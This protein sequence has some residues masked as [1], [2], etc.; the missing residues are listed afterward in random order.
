MAQPKGKA[1]AAKKGKTD[2]A[3]KPAGKPAPAKNLE[4]ALK[5]APPPPAQAKNPFDRYLE[6]L[7]TMPIREDALKGTGLTA[8]DIR[9]RSESDPEFARKLSLAWDIGIDVAEDAAFRRGIIGWDEPVFT[10]DGGLAG[11]VTR[12]DGGLLKEVLKANRAK[13]RG[14]DIGRSR[15]VSEETRREV[16]RVFEEAGGL[17]V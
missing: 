2:V 15:G 8:L 10:K 11:H 6:Q 1:G 3:A 17:V 12:Y 14:E 9:L 7:A 16:H 13:Y 5:P 4:T